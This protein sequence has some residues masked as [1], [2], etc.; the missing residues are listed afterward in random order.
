MLNSTGV[1][2]REVLA[3]A[4]LMPA[5][6]ELHICCNC[7]S[8]TYLLILMLIV[9]DMSVVFL[10]LHLVIQSDSFFL[11]LFSEHELPFG[12]SLFIFSF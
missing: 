7:E 1:P 10:V 3:L 5:L 6:R 11:P 2:L 4:R 8:Q 9:L 12:L